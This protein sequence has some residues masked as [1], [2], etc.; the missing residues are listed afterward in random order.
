LTGA[1]ERG[2]WRVAAVARPKFIVKT[3]FRKLPF[4]FLNALYSGNSD[5][6]FK[7]FSAKIFDG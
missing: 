7:H 2:T 3:S 5:E 4:G 1:A 6:K